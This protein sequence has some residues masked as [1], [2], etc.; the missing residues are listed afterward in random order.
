VDPPTVF[1]EDPSCRWRRTITASKI[2]LDDSQ[3]HQNLESTQATLGSPQSPL[4]KARVTIIC[5]SRYG[6]IVRFWLL[7]S[8]LT[9][10]NHEGT[11]QPAICYTGQ[12]YSSCTTDGG[13]N[14]SVR[15]LVGSIEDRLPMRKT[16]KLKLCKDTPCPSPIGFVGEFSFLLREPEAMNDGSV[17]RQPICA[18]C[19]VLRCF[20]NLLRLVIKPGKRFQGLGTLCILLVTGNGSWNRFHST[21]CYSV[22]IR[23]A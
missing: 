7:V 6:E 23:R 17:V 9:F 15:P 16:G 5:N 10:L 12:I 2:C 11:R 4:W 8:D 21:S 1:P 13:V 14:E 22:L 3:L 20:E 19:S 18:H